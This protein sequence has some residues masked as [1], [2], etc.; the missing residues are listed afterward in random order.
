MQTGLPLTDSEMLD[1]RRLSV[2]TPAAR[3]HRRA[4]KPLAALGHVEGGLGLGLG[5]GGTAGLATAAPA[6]LT[7]EQVPPVIRIVLHVPA[8]G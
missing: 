3:L 8:V 2:E 6:R 4:H 7:E 1:L 5:A